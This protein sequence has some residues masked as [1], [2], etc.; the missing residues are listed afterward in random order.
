MPA[1][2]R[3]LLADDHPLVRAGLRA[4]LASEDDITLVGEAADGHETQRLARDL[5]PDVLLLDVSMPGPAAVETVAHVRAQ[6]PGTKV[7]IVTAYH[8]PALSRG[9]LAAGV[10][11]YLLKDEPNAA[12]VRAIRVVVQGGSW[13]SRPIMEALVQPGLGGASGVPSSALTEQEAAVLQLMVAG[14]ADVEIGRALHISERTVRRHLRSIYDKLQV[15]TR[16]EAAV[17]AVQLGLVGAHS[18]DEVAP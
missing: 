4:A 1:A 13:V 15:N 2:I 6:C 11:G 5:R 16:V 3:V 12:L 14:Q 9:L 7:L 10:A 18:Q 8:S 17:R